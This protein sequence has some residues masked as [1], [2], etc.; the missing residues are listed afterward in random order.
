MRRRIMHSVLR[1]TI[2]ENMEYITSLERQWLIRKLEREL[3]RPWLPLPQGELIL[4][5]QE[6]D[7]MVQRLT[8]KRSSR[9]QNVESRSEH[10]QIATAANVG[11]RTT[12]N[13]ESGRR[14]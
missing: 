7:A 4:T 5:P 12:S 3:K 10:V 11:L 1:R 2:L 6:R 13:I 14:A 9:V 8:L